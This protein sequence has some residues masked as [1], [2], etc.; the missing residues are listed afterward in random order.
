MNTVNLLAN[1]MSGNEVLAYVLVFLGLIIEGEIVILFA[2]ILAHLGGLDFKSLF[3][4]GALSLATKAFL[5]YH[6]GSYLRDRFPDNR[7]FQYIE[8]KILYF[9]PSF[10]EKPFWSIFISKFIYGINHLAIVLSGFLKIDFK[11]FFKAEFS[12]SIIWLLE[13]LALGYFF[14][15]YAIGI[16]K[17]IRKFTLL[18]LG[19]VVAFIL[20]ERFITFLFQLSKA[21]PKR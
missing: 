12:A 8:N 6:L 2:G 11:T 16:T 14:S 9:L 20:L 10:K 5:G 4:V 1:F 21:K 3:L 13:F 7:F 19:F 15:Y 18:V 17:D